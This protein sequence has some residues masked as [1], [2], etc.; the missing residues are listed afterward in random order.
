MLSVIESTVQE[1]T[2][3]R[4]TRRYHAWELAQAGW[5]QKDIADKLGVTTSAVSQ[6]LKKARENGVNDLQR[7]VSTGAPAVLR[8]DEQ[9]E[10][11]NMLLKGATYFGYPDDR[12][13][14]KRVAD[15]IYQQFGVFYSDR[16]AGRLLNKL[17][18]AAE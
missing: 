14:R 10:L 7:R 1:R 5:Q 11:Q 6:W 15:L 16:H 9:S 8:S 4:E 17:S 12:W 2:D 18:G 13:T 3:W